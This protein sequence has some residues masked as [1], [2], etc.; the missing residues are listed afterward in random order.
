MQKPHL[1]EADLIIWACGYQTQKIPIKDFE[2][3]EILL[4]QR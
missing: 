3:K 1:E 2:G 4:S